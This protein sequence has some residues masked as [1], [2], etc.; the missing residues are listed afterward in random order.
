MGLRGNFLKTQVPRW[1]LSR[2]T[3]STKPYLVSRRS[4]VYISPISPEKEDGRGMKEGDRQ[5]CDA[6][7][8]LPLENPRDDRAMSLETVRK[9]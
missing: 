2:P 9:T 6:P 4:A 1:F 8:T 5:I 7:K 3:S